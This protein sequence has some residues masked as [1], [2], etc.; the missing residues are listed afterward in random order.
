MT[1][2]V[3]SSLQRS[4]RLGN[5]NG[6]KVIQTDAPVN[7]GNSGGPLVNLE[8][9]VVAITTAMIPHAKGIGFAIPID[10]ALEVA[11]QII[12]HGE[13]RRPWLGIVG[14]DVNRRV[15]RRY[16]VLASRGIFV[17]EVSAGGPAEAAGLRVGDVILSVDGEPVAS[18]GELV[19]AIRSKKIGQT[20]AMEVERRGDKRQFEANLGSR[21]F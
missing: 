18:V 3:V 1:S 2:G 8:G 14:Y 11:R 17:V 16:G 9:K 12:E 21:P 19:E 5:G 7:P 13:V 20:L 15:A 6:L 10:A 4:L